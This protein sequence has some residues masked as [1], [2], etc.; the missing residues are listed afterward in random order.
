MPT[1]GAFCARQA[2]STSSGTSNY[3]TGSPAGRLLPELPTGHTLSYGC[4][5]RRTLR[6]TAPFQLWHSATSTIGSWFWMTLDM[7]IAAND[8][9]QAARNLMDRAQ[10]GP[11][12]LV[13][14]TALEL[15]SLGGPAHPLFDQV[16]SRA[17]TCQGQ[18]Q[19]RQAVDQATQGLVRRGLLIDTTSGT[20]PEQPIETCAL[21]P[22]LRLVL[23]ARGHPAFAV[24]VEAEDRN[25]RALRLFALGD[26]AEP[27]RGFVLEEPGLPLNPERYFAEVSE[28]GP[29]GWF[30]R[31]VLV[32]R[33][34]AAD[35]LARW[36]VS[37][38]W[39]P[40]A[41]ASPGWL[42][43]AWYPGRKNPAGYRLRIRGDGSRARLDGLARG[44]PAEYDVEG[45][46]VVMRDLLSARRGEIRTLR[47]PS[48]AG[49]PPAS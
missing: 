33:D 32:S 24:I 17:W 14:V 47:R 12:D 38:P 9:T 8:R 21:K 16:P 20:G 4:L 30:Y 18:R 13:T 46:H 6:V 3:S 10:T 39:P 43:S 44:A 19:R 27:L 22:E 29:L 11:V 36:T 34:L 48:T 23:A 37:P 25:L 1:G 42:L 31:Y 26:E 5:T 40:G 41:P 7:D 2:R 49:L 35:T 45:L 28:L 15:C